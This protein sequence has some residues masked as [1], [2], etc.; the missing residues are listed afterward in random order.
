[1]IIQIDTKNFEKYFYNKMNGTLVLSE[2]SVIV[3][4]PISTF[5]KANVKPCLLNF[6]ERLFEVWVAR[7]VRRWFSGTFNEVTYSSVVL[8]NFWFSHSI[9]I[10]SLVYFLSIDP[11]PLSSRKKWQQQKYFRFALYLKTFNPI[12][13]IF[14]HSSVIII[15]IILD[16]KPI[17]L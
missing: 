12:Y 5:P 6:R 11:L 9:V 8:L 7:Y 15:V 4:Q 3:L 13:G 17:D 2:E 10:K 16:Q 1:M 14:N